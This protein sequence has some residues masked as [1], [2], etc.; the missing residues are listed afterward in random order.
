MKRAGPITSDVA[1]GKTE[2]LAE[3]LWKA[4][5]KRE[6]VG[7]DDEGYAVHISRGKLVGKHSAIRL[8]RL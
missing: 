8:Y 6:V 2:V 7:T 4:T 5:I 3:K 1:S